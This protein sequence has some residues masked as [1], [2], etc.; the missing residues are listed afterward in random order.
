[1]VNK[2]SLDL[3]DIF[4]KD[5]LKGYFARRVLDKIIFDRKKSITPME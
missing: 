5:Y 2:M 3:K 4:K 1:M